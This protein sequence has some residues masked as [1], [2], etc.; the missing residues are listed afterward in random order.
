VRLLFDQ[1]P[2]VDYG[3]LVAEMPKIRA[4]SDYIDHALFDATPLFEKSVE[5]NYY[6]LLRMLQFMRYC[7]VSHA[8]HW[9]IINLA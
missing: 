4:E 5:Y 1:K 3:K 2:D 6:V 8:F 9:H 7:K